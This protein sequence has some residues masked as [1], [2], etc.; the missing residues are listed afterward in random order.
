MWESGTLVGTD[1]YWEAKV[2]DKPSKYGINGGRVSKLHVW[3]DVEIGPV[4]DVFC[5]DREVRLDTLPAGILDRI[6]GK[7]QDD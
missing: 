4:L 7:I 1:F 5:Y 2:Y 6:L 3:R